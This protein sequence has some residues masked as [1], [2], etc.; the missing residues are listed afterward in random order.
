MPVGYSSVQ[1]REIRSPSARVDDSPINEGPIDSD[2]G[3]RS[4][5]TTDG[6]QPTSRRLDNGFLSCSLQYVSISRPQCLT[7]AWPFYTSSFSPVAECLAPTLPVRDVSLSFSLSLSFSFATL[8][9]HSLLPA[10]FLQ[11]RTL[12]FFTNFFPAALLISNHLSHVRVHNPGESPLG[13][14]GDKTA[15]EDPR[16]GVG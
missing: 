2:G 11:D 3:R 5:V 15:R 13:N 1:R 16:W 4:E 6:A 9:F 14:I 8:A 12:A 10:V 7:D